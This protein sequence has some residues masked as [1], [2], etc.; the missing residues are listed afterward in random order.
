MTP[1]AER[2][3]SIPEVFKAHHLETN[4]NQAEISQTLK[5]DPIDLSGPNSELLKDEPVVALRK[6]ERNE[7]KNKD[8]LG[9]IPSLGKP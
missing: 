4:P 7:L 9:S 3:E 5:G 6:S 8:V 2:T 1:I